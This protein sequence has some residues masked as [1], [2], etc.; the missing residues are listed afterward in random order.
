QPP[1][2]AIAGS[3]GQALPARPT[4]SGG[5]GGDAGASGNAGTDWN[6]M[7]H[8]TYF[9]GPALLVALALGALVALGGGPSMQRTVAPSTSDGTNCRQLGERNGAVPFEPA[10]RTPSP[11]G[12]SVVFSSV[13]P[14]GSW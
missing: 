9:L 14:F 5:S 2:L 8:L 13:P 12:A 3:L 4:S 10:R 6:G 7:K 11:V 1:S